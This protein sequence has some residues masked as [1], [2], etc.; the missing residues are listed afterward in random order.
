[1]LALGAF[2]RGIDGE[3]AVCTLGV[4]LVWGGPCVVPFG[5]VCSLGRCRVD[6]LDA[7]PPPCVAVCVPAEEGLCG[8]LGAD[9]LPESITS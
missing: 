5:S 1:M 8:L 7:G 3:C 2:C 6:S 4:C 9:V